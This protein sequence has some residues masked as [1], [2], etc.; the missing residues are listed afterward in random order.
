[1][2]LEQVVTHSPTVPFNRNSN[3]SNPEDENGLALYMNPGKTGK[4]RGGNSWEVLKFLVNKRPHSSSR[5][6]ISA[7]AS[8]TFIFKVA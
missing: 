6:T 7:L 3:S 1:M 2:L 8:P 4:R 5:R